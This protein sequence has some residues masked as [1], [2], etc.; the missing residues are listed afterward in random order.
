MEQALAE[1]HPE[2]LS[3]AIPLYPALDAA[4]LK[5]PELSLILYPDVKTG[6]L[7]LLGRNHV[8]GAELGSAYTHSQ[9][10]G[11]YYKNAFEVTLPRLVLM[12]LTA[13]KEAS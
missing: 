3:A 8:T 11:G 10:V 9:I 12:L 4:R 6:N 1:D 2:V 13:Q 7:L 5:H